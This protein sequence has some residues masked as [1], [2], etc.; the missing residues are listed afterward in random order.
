LSQEHSL[1][2]AGSTLAAQL[3]TPQPAGGL[4][5]SVVEQ[6]RLHLV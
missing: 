6:P 4:L 3:V 2:K 1:T 5:P